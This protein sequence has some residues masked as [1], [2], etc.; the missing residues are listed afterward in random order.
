MYCIARVVH[1]LGWPIGWV[2]LVVGREFLFVGLGNGSEMADLRKIDV[3]YITAILH[4]YVTLRWEAIILFCENFHFGGSLHLLVWGGAG[5]W[6]HKFTWQWIRLGWVKVGLGLGQYEMEYNG[7]TG[8]SVHTC[9][10]RSRRLPF[11]PKYCLDT[12]CSLR[13]FS[14]CYELTLLTELR[15]PRWLANIALHT[16]L[17]LIYSKTLG[18][19]LLFCVT[20]LVIEL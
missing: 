14:V 20:S 7:P 15:Q 9:S 11:G 5:S 18:L 4:T 2:G 3:V 12:F 8:S 10:S 16:R 13:R 19:Y 6:V 17:R 1:G